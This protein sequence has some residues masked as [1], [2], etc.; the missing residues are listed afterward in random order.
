MKSESRTQLTASATF[1]VRLSSTRR[2]ARLA[3]RFAAQQLDEWG[4][5]YTSH[6]AYAVRVVVAELA[7]N[8]VLHGRLP[9]RDFELRL[10]Q[11]PE[12]IRIEVSDTRPERVPAILQPTPADDVQEHGHGLLLIAAYADRWGCHLR[13][14]YV[15][16]V[17]AEVSCMLR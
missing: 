2:G 16:T 11:H 13:D 1:I 15:K 12:M 7:A 10:L 8:A 6:A 4:I 9:G 14:K 17:W 3:R 5:P